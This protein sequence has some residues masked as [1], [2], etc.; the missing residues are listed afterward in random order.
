MESSSAYISSCISA[1]HVELPSKIF[2]F[3]L[4]KNYWYVIMIKK[5][6]VTSLSS[7]PG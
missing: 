5:N 7:L 3:L 6:K 2:K 4:F 1:M